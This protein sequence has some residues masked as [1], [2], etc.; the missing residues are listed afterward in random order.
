[1][2]LLATRNRNLFLSLQG[3]LRHL[4]ER[5]EKGEEIPRAEL[6]ELV[7]T[8]QEQIAKALDPAPARR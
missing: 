6:E 7:T 8:M 3:G 5:L 4:A 1:M 2:K